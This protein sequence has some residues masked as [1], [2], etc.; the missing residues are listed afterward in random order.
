MWVDM[1]LK[2]CGI[3][4]TEDALHAVT[5]GATAVGFV[6]WPASPRA[7]TFDRA[8]AI[9]GALPAGVVK[10]G[11]FVNAVRDEVS[12]AVRET[13]ITMVQLHGDE[14]PEYAAAIG[15]PVVRSVTLG[16]V[17][18]VQTT[19]P[20]D[21]TLLLDA[22]DAVRRGGTGT[23]V[24]WH[25]AAAIARHRRIILAGGLT[26]RNVAAAIAA[27]RPFGVDVSSGVEAAP[28]I[29]DEEQVAQFL[30]SARMAFAND[31]QGA[32]EQR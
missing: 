23:T 24:D 27:V 5:H 28:G 12:R 25:A 20:V 4:R 6:F 10:V 19:W 11:V 3:T 32:V 29:K 14:P 17:A 22:A 9:V 13:G 16:N 26:S 15:V 7:V 30:A 18:H 31:A 2:I 8:A 21:I 1:F